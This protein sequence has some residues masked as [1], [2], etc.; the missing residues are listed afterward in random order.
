MKN[1]TIWDTVAGISGLG[2]LFCWGVGWGSGLGVWFC[3]EG[4]GGGLAWGCGFL[5]ASGVCGGEHCT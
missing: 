4:L 2:I 3:E 5:V 1:I